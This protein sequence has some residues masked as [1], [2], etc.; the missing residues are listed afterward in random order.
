MIMIPADY[1]T[2]NKTLELAYPWITPESMAWL[3]CYLTKSMSAIEFGCGGST[4]FLAQRCDHVISMDNNKSWTVKT[5][6]A[7]IDKKLSNASVYD[8]TCVA[9]C[10]NLINRKFTLAF[11][12]CCDI[13]RVDAAEYMST[14]ADLVLI[15]NYDAE[16]SRGTDIYY[17]SSDWSTLCFDDVHWVGRGTKIY[18]RR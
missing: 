6:Q 4:I 9:E 14:R 10:K 2:G 5:R 8:V 18:V 16:Y 13:S 3:D 12:D 7:L 17:P 15:D 11:I 1:Y